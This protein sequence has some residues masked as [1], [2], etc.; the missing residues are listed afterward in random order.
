MAELTREPQPRRRTRPSLS[1]W[2]EIRIVFAGIATVAF[3]L[4][5]YQLRSLP[6]GEPYSWVATGLA[7]LAIVAAIPRAS[8]D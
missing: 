3:G 6:G 2:D 8:T 5:A 7:F 1:V 4:A